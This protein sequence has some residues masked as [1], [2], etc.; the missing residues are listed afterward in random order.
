MKKQTAIAALAAV[1]AAPVWAA[2]VYQQNFEANSNGLAGGSVESSQGYSGYGFGSQLFWSDGT[3][4]L[5]LNLGQSVQNANLA[6]SLAII[7]SWDNGLGCCGP[8][9]FQ[10]TLNGNA[11]PLFDEVFANF[12]APGATSAAGLS[13]SVYNQHLGFNGSFPDA[14]YTLSL[15]L[16]NLSAG[17]HTISFMAYGP[18]WQAGTDESFGLDNI[19]VSGTLPAAVPEPGS[20]ALAALGLAGLGTLR[21]RSRG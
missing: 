21:R 10:I 12:S 3:S 6:F 1:L 8:D 11:T 14:A 13:N 4:T 18:G 9:K 16:G 2:N 7:D 20:L 15:A 19:V 5:T 17:I